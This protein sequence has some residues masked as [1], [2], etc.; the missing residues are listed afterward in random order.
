M[1]NIYKLI[2]FILIIATSESTGQNYSKESENLV[3]NKITASGEKVALFKNTAES[4]TMIV[5]DLKHNTEYSLEGIS[6][7][8][9]LNEEVF[10]GWNS[11]KQKL[12]RINFRS[13]QVDSVDNVSGFH[14]HDKLDLLVQYQ[15]KAEK[16]ILTT[17]SGDVIKV[18]GNV[19]FY[20]LSESMDKLLIFTTD[21]KIVWFD[22]V[23]RNTIEKKDEY[24]INYRIKRIL[25][26]S[27]ERAYI[28]SSNQHE[29]TILNVDEKI[30]NKVAVL[31]RND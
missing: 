27:N 16:I 8:T 12:Y 18:F 20:S 29:I 30:L 4:A 22:M 2:L 19:N 5:K 11:F 14:W 17:S 31:K 6:N 28:L 10:I 3:N 13:R 21:H 23:S 9:V 25:W 24:L 26:C 1:G 15:G 7:R